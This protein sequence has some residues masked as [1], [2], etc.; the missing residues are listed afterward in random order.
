MRS[1]ALVA[2]LLV[3]AL[4]AGC[5][6][7]AAGSDN[8]VSAGSLLQK[9]TAN[10][11][12]W[13]PQ[14]R[15]V[16]LAGLELAGTGNQTEQIQ[17]ARDA[18][19][20]FAALVPGPDAKV[21]DGKARAWEFVFAS[22]SGS[23]RIVLAPNGEVTFRDEKATGSLSPT[24]GNFT[25]DSD[26]A[27]G[28]AKQEPKFAALI[29]SAD[30]GSVQLTK[31]GNRTDWT[32]AIGSSSG[33]I[34]VSVIVNVD[35]HSGSVRLQGSAGTIPKGNVTKPPLPAKEFGD[36]AGSAAQGTTF[37]GAF[38]L[39]KDHGNLSFYLT[40]PTPQPASRLTVT[41]SM[42]DGTNFN[43]QASAGVAGL[44]GFGSPEASHLERDV[45]LGEYKVAVSE[46]TPATTQ[47]FKVSWCT[48]E[49]G[50]GGSGNAAC[51]SF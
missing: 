30:S 8:T 31:N 1:A 45:K 35:S 7:G 11:Q 13:N 16:G 4:L 23:L 3:S 27:A 34:P 18:S 24:V 32:I 25:V 39:K 26:S 51:D 6:G 20:E 44:P 29:D 33:P 14:A 21:G 10:A 9:A 41:I 2:F 42:P 47:D 28:L 19:K 15:L 50:T 22:S 48:S 46:G 38:T 17:K 43:M 49:P 12:A 36:V 40:M 5:G 37:N